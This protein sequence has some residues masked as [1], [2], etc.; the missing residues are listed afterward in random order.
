MTRPTV[1]QVIAGLT[2][3]VTLPM[4]SFSMLLAPVAQDATA[5]SHREAPMIAD[6]PAADGTDVYAFTSP[7]NN[8]TVTLIYNTWPFEDPFGGPNFYRF[9]ENVLYSI[10]V[11]NNGDNVQ[12]ISYD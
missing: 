2:A 5:S 3:A 11:D 1:G 8:G 7:E 9:D 10:K 6:D 12:D 4:A